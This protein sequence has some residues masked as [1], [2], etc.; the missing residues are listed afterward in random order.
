MS[1]AGTQGVAPVPRAELRRLAHGLATWLAFEHQC[2][3]DE[4]FSERYLASP[5]AQLL[6]AG[7][8]GKV[9]AEHN[10]PVLAKDE[11]E[12]RPAQL[13]FVIRDVKKIRLAVET[14]WAGQRGISAWSIVWDCVRLELAAHE[15]GC[16]GLFVLAGSKAN[17]DKMLQSKPLNPKT[18]R[19]RPSPV[20]SLNGVGRWSVNIQS[21]ERDFGPALHR[22]LAMYPEVEFPRS[23]VCG[24][25]VRMPTSSKE[26][27]YV[28]A[29]W[30]IQPEAAIKRFTFRAPPG[31]S[32]APTKEPGPS[33]G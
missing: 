22:R 28:A 1:S 5:I 25:G 29:V 15:Y 19:G 9:V 14:K 17:M 16:T 6:A 30:C 26:H 7:N 32:S 3:R 24:N 13:D 12:G 20:M 18:S 2:G 33:N 27:E 21:P 11:G 10:H 4:L 31:T 8:S 23:Y